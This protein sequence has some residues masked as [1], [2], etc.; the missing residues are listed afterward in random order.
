MT[1]FRNITMFFFNII[2]WFYYSLVVSPIFGGSIMGIV[3]KFSH[4]YITAVVGGQALGGI[5][6]ALT[7]IAAL[8][9]G[10]SST[11]SALV[12]F[13]IGNLT[14][15]LAILLY[16][17]LSKSAFFN[18]YV[19]DQSVINNIQNESLQYQ[20]VV[21]YRIVLKKIW[22]YGLCIFFIFVVTISV[23]PGV[24]VLIES[25]GKGHGSR[26]SGE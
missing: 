17:Y 11:H 6:A 16:L 12:Y 19:G 26:W 4:T 24:M 22:A 20:E 2:S 1:T 18:F 8:A 15:L 7:Q 14:I 21:S 25:E 5:F 13:I 10:A 3:G 23:F 9:I